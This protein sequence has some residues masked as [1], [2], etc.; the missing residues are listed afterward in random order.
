[1]GENDVIHLLSY[2]T[3]TIINF[4]N[5]TLDQKDELIEIIE[6]IKTRNGQT[7]LANPL[8]NASYAMQDS[9]GKN[10]KNKRIFVFSDG[11][12]NFGEIRSDHYFEKIINK[13]VNEYKVNITTIGFSNEFDEY[14]LQQVSKVGKGNFFYIK[15]KE[16]MNTVFKKAFSVMSS[17]YIKNAKLTLIPANDSITFRHEDCVKSEIL[18]PV[19]V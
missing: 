2:D 9:I 18:L 12:V 14:F 3:S 15:N 13:Y 7:N 19:L 10:I 17:L 5:G 4:S 16:D 1:M 11:I 6:A 8:K